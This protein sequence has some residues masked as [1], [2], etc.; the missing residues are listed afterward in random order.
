VSAG[1]HLS[2]AGKK[3]KAD[4]RSISYSVSSGTVFLFFIW[5]VFVFVEKETGNRTKTR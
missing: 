2:R 3:K 4:V 1:P 5:I